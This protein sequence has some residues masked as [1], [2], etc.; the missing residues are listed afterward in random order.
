MTLPRKNRRHKTKLLKFDR[1]REYVESRLADRWSPEQIA[2]RLRCHLPPGL[3]GQTVCAESIYRYVYDDRGAPWLYHQ[4]RRRHPER[5]GH[6]K[7]HHRIVSIPDRVSIHDRP[8]V[9]DART[10]Y[11]HWESDSIVGAKHTG[12]LSVQ[13]ERMSQYVKVHPLTSFTADETYAAITQSIAELPAGCVK[14]ITFDNGGEGARHVDLR[15]AHNVRT[16]H[17]DPYASWQKGG[18]E[19]VNGLIRQYVPKRASMTHYTAADI[20]A[21]EAKL[22]NRPRKG[23]GYRTPHEVLCQQ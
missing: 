14:S 11:G 8:A 6:G 21:I 2:G 15:Y 4:L 13:Y 22:N 17:C 5:R 16:Y 1:L 10:E 19:N 20:R 3:G 9:I 23:L 7:R 12:G 18:V